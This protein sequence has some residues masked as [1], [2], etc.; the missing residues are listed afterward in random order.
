MFTPEEFETM[1]RERFRQEGPGV[2]VAANSV[3]MG[4]VLGAMRAE[5]VLEQQVHRPQGL[6]WAGFRM[7]FCLWICGPMNTSELSRMLFTTAPTVSS[8]LNTMEGRGFVERRRS[9]E[10]R[11]QVSVHLTPVG[12]KLIARAF[13]AQHVLEKKWT[14]GLPPSDIAAFLRVIR[15]L[16][17]KVQASA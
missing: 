13:R 11:R 15:H 9:N 6:T 5:V 16:T 8:V 1:L 7:L 4:M 12:E 17:E 2:D 14:A 10:D 3:I